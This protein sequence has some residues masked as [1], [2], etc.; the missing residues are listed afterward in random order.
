MRTLEEMQMDALRMRRSIIDGRMTRGTDPYN[1]TFDCSPEETLIL[2]DAPGH[3]V[4]LS[5]E[6][7][8]ICGLKISV[9]AKR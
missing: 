6:R 3:P 7:D 2:K 9:S 8:R 4:T 1:Y 5:R